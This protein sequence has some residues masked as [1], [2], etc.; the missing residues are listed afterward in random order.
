MVGDSDRRWVI[1]AAYAGLDEWHQSLVPLRN[2]TPRDAA[3]D[4]FGP[5]LAQGLVWGVCDTKMALHSPFSNAYRDNKGAT[6]NT[7]L[8]HSARGYGTLAGTSLEGILSPPL[9]STAVV[10]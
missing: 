1:A 2:A 6:E 10:T 7:W 4:A 5:L 3:I 8:T 9:E